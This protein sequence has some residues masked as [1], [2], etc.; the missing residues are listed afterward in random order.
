MIRDETQIVTVVVP[1]IAPLMEMITNNLIV[2]RPRNNGN[3]KNIGIS[4]A[5]V[6]EVED[7]GNPSIAH[8]IGIY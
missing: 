7:V 4:E 8:F 6:K 1:N 2:L 5:G 3:K